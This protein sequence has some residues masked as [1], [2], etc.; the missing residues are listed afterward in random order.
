MDDI[1]E[2]RREA[3][4]LPDAN[5]REGALWYFRGDTC[6]SELKPKIGRKVQY[7]GR[8][9]LL[10]ERQE[11][12]LL[13]RFRRFAHRHLR[14]GASE[15]EA[16]F[17][18]RHYGLP[19]RIMDWTT[20]PL[21]ATY[22]ACSPLDVSPQDGVVWGVLRQQQIIEDVDVL[23]ANPGPLD[24]YKGEA[25]VK[26][27]YP[28]YNSWRLTAQQGRFTWH[29]EPRLALDQL[30]N[31]PFEDK[32]L[33]IRRLVKWP[34]HFG[35]ERTSVLQH[36]ER[37]GVSQRTVFPD[38]SGIA[39]GLWHTEVLFNGHPSEGKPPSV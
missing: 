34:L 14:S 19:T 4:A 35:S 1:D 3:D 17:L 10:D 37:F 2:V 15:W 21:V 28:V 7:G 39:S 8:E 33:D 27:I 18:A 5:Q 16:L 26:L 22:F 23:K 31:L 9:L 30:A 29:S 32:H 36:L 20:S 13:H 6:C 11:S 38:L 12:D 25:A 24:L